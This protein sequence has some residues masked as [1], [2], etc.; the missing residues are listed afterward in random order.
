MQPALPRNRMN[1]I[2]CTFCGKKNH[3]AEDYYFNIDSPNCKLPLNMKES[4][5][6]MKNIPTNTSKKSKAHHFGEYLSFGTR[7]YAIR[8]EI[9]R[10]GAIRDSGDTISMFKNT[11]EDLE[12]S[13]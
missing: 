1:V 10:S 5:K 6:S 13:Y 8:S 9:N 12:G 3:T 2:T 11:S 7:H 4:F